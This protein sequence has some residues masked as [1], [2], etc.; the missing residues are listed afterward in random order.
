[1][2]LH[3]KQFAAAPLLGICVCAWL[4]AS[5][6]HADDDQSKTDKIAASQAAFMEAYKV[7]MHPRCMN[8]HPAGDRPLQ[9]DDSHVH[10][11]NVQRGPK[12]EGKYALKCANCHQDANLTGVHMPPGNP[13]WALTTPGMPMVFEG[14]TPHQLALQMKDAKQNGH[15]NLQQIYDHIAHD[16]LVSWGWDPGDGRTKPPLNRDE[17]AKKMR[18]WIDGGAAAPE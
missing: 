3:P 13:K 7:F 9:G 8:C 11:M 5:F 1:M 16:D 15:R 4:A 14:H 17:F 6:L 18:E 12:G 10:T 2:Y